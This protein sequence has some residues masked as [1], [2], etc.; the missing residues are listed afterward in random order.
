[1]AVPALATP[2][3]A[4]A[5]A[6]PRDEI[7]YI[8]SAE[9]LLEADEEIADY[10]LL[11]PAESVALGIEIM[12]G[13]GRDHALLP[14]TELDDGTTLR[15]NTAVQVWLT[16]AEANRADSIFYGSSGASAPVEVTIVT[17]SVPARTRQR[18]VLLKVVQQ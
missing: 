1:M 2:F 5:Q 18:T 10:E 16:V 6:D 12:E 4:A 7:E 17:T 11:L 14:E 13:G 8:I 9:G 15:A 3:P